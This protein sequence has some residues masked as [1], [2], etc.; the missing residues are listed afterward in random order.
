MP[1]DG[2]RCP[3]LHDLEGCAH[4]VPA[5]PSPADSPIAEGRLVPRSA[6]RIALVAS[7]G[8]IVG[9][10]P[11]SSSIQPTVVGAHRRVVG[12]TSPVYSTSYEVILVVKSHTEGLRPLSDSRTRPRFSMH[13]GAWPH[14]WVAVSTALDPRHPPPPVCMSTHRQPV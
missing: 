12:P 7:G 3:G 8:G 10:C 6:G 2:G 14:G 13:F 1:T 4:P 5:A 11:A 9:L